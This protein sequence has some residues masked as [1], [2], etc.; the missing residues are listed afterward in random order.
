MAENGIIYL[1]IIKLVRIQIFWSKTKYLIMIKLK[2]VKDSGSET[3]HQDLPWTI[4]AGF[5][6]CYVV[7]LACWKT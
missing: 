4:P 6:Q 7:D 1:L 2:L 5:L 3:I